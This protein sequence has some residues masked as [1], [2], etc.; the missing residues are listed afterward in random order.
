MSREINTSSLKTNIKLQLVAL[1]F[2]LPD[3]SHNPVIHHRFELVPASRSHPKPDSKFLLWFAH[4]TVKCKINLAAKTPDGWM[5]GFTSSRFK[6]QIIHFGE[7][8]ISFVGPRHHRRGGLMKNH[9]GISGLAQTPAVIS[10]TVS[11]S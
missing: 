1:H 4:I 11:S 2:L 6:S 9:G 8:G 5:D 7:I 10:V 3:K